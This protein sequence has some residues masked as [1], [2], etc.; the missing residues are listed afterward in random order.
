[1]SSAAASREL[2]RSKSRSRTDWLSH[3]S[4]RMCS[5][6]INSGVSENV[7]VPPSP[8]SWSQAAPTAGFAAIPLVASEPPHSTP[9]RSWLASHDVR[10][11]VC[12]DCQRESAISVPLVTV[13]IVPP[14]SRTEMVS[15]RRSPTAT[16]SANSSRPMAS[17]PRPIIRDA[18]TFGFVPTPASVRNICSR[19]AA[20]GSPPI[21]CGV[22]RICAPP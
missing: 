20:G 8:T 14:V 19:A 4:V 3:R 11:I 5:A 17:V 10:S 21:W 9:N 15:T 1:M 16:A 7:A 2:T 18:P 13:A 22:E 6:P 12:I